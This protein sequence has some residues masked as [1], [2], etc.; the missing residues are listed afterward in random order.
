MKNNDKIALDKI[1]DE[2]MLAELQ[3]L[4]QNE[5]DRPADERDYNYIA[6]LT[7][8][9]IEIAGARSEPVPAEDI[10]S[11]VK[12][13]KKRKNISRISKWSAALSACLVICVAVNFYTV[14][15]FGSNIFSTALRIAKDGFSLNLAE[16]SDNTTATD[17]PLAVI[18]PQGTIV[19]PDPGISDPQDEASSDAVQME[20]MKTFVP[21][22]FICYKN[23]LIP[24]CPNA[25]EGIDDIDFVDFYHA[26]N[27]ISDDYVFTF[28]NDFVKLNITLEKYEKRSDIPENLIPSESYEVTQRVFGNT[29]VG[30]VMSFIFTEENSSTMI[31]VYDS[32]VYTFCIYGSDLDCF[33][34]SSFTFKPDKKELLAYVDTSNPDIWWSEHLPELFER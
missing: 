9:I 24:C 16:I 12:A 14:S 6:E 29:P 27:E 25:L 10:L 11:E 18:G 19:P 31:F 33:K 30:D 34:T 13:R 22:E 20:W 21:M 5:L 28:E 26:Q 17:Y 15:S 23:G 4:L 1:S 3:M 32:T 2:K 8:T 7:G